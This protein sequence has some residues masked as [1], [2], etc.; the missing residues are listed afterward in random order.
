M[1]RGP[2]KVGVTASDPTSPAGRHQRSA[3]ESPAIINMAPWTLAS[4][5]DQ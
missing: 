1:Q 4:E 2:T 3:C 5:A